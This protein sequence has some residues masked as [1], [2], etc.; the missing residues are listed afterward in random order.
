MQS[1]ETQLNQALEGIKQRDELIASLKST[2]HRKQLII[3]SIQRDWQMKEAKLSG[4]SIKR[5]HEAFA[6]STNNAGLK[7]AINVERKRK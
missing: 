4:D 1:L 2:I 5:L 6:T 3:A 7:E